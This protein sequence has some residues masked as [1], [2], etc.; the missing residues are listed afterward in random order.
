M[1]VPAGL[2]FSFA[3]DYFEFLLLDVQGK[4][5]MGEGGQQRG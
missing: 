5:F 4:T 2:V 3:P 1:S